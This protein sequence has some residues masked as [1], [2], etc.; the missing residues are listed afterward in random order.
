MENCHKLDEEMAMNILNMFNS[1]D[2]EN[3]RLALEII[4]NIDIHD[5]K[6]IDLVINNILHKSYGLRFS[7]FLDENQDKKIVFHYDDGMI[8]VNDT[9][10]ILTWNPWV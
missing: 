7:I 10:T 6:T 1:R 5:S 8:F 2:I 3:I 4:N 9:E